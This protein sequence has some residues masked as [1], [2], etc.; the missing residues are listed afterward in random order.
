MSTPAPRHTEAQQAGILVWGLVAAKASRALAPLVIVRL[1]GQGDV[2][3]LAT[4]MLVYETVAVLL[5]AGFPR[6]IQYFHAGRPIEERR[7]ITERLTG[8]MVVSGVVVA[9]MLTGLGTVGLP[10]LHAVTNFLFSGWGVELELGESAQ[11]VLP[12]LPWIGAYAIFDVPTKLGPNL[13]LAEGRAR[14]SAVI[15]LLASLGQ[16]IGTL[17]PASLGWGVT[18]ILAGQLLFGVVNFGVYAFLAHGLY[19]GVTSAQSDVT[20][21]ELFRVSVPLGATDVVITLNGSVDRWLIAIVFTRFEVAEYEMG[22]WQIPIVTNIAYSVGAVYLRRLTELYRAGQPREALAL[23]RASIPK[24][25]LVVVPIAG[26]FVVSAEDFVVMLFT[27]EYRGAAPV[28]RAYCLLTMARVTAFGSLIIASGNAGNVLRASGLSL[29]F[30]LVIS[31]PLV[32]T[33]GFYGPALG[34]VLAF[35]PTVAIYCHYIAK[36]SGVSIRETFPLVAYLQVVAVAAVPMALAGLARTAFP[37]APNG[38]RMALVAVIVL[39]G[40]AVLGTLTRRITREDWAFLGD[41]LRMRV[42]R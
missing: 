28:F 33:M 38:A 18:G 34:T 42:L 9:A 30:N 19:R 35:I 7:A 37:D 40:F 1:L 23:W 8:L 3:L 5:I 4:M 39:V 14:S 6:S 27:D 20:W 13:M 36:G 17:V 24:V 26:V 25:A 22:A 12:L 32:L 29:L 2:G 10:A 21:R 11:L 16:M 41:W 31:T 15:S